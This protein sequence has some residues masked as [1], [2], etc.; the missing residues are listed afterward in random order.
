MRFKFLEHTADIKFQAFGNS[1]DKVFENSGYA[2]LN[3][4]IETEIKEIKKKKLSVSGEDLEN[5]LYNFLEEFLFLIDSENFLVGKIIDSKIK[6]NKKYILDVEVLGD[7]VKNY[8]LEG[9]VKA[10][11]YNEMFVEKDGEKWVS[12]VVVDV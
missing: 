7:D 1:L 11:T 8:N 3:I 4:L 6:K 2:L 5:L 10:I 9:D 12:Q